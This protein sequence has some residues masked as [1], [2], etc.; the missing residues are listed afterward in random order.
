MKKTINILL[1]VTMCTFVIFAHY[2][3]KSVLANKINNSYN[4]FG[5][6]KTVNAAKN[7]YLDYEKIS[8]SPTI[9]DYNWLNGKLNFGVLSI[10]DFNQ[11]STS[12]SSSGSSAQEM[13]SSYKGSLIFKINLERKLEDV[14]NYSFYNKLVFAMNHC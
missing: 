10:E 4:A 1:I 11:Y 7:V 13:V 5:I 8:N 9:F 12:I 14:F 6:G 3:E 2:N